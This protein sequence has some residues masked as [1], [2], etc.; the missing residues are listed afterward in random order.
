MLRANLDNAFRLVDDL[1]QNFAL[2]DGQRKR[3]LGVNVFAAAA[4]RNV[5]R[6][7]PMVGRPVD[8]HVDVAAFKHFA[9]VGVDL[10]F[11]FEPLP[12]PLGMPGVHIA[13]S[14]DIPELGGLR[15]YRG[16]T[17]TD[18][19]RANAEPIGLRLRLHRFEV[20]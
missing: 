15:E 18:T 5:D 9:I 19:N 1:G 2:V 17:T 3:L 11:A 14:H 16:S 4:G 12:S 7:V 20:K 13:N 10:R 8:D 6:R